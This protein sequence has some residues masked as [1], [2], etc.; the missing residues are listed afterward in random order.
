M[1]K[2]DGVSICISL[3]ILKTGGDSKLVLQLEKCSIWVTSYRSAP[4]YPRISFTIRPR[5]NNVEFMLRS[6]NLF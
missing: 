1:K 3:A 5:E 6:A 4:K 2:V